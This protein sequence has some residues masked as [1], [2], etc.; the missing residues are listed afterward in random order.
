MFGRVCGATTAYGY[1]LSIWRAGDEDA[2]QTWNGIAVS[3]V[4]H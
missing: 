1:G 4:T 3:Y 2:G